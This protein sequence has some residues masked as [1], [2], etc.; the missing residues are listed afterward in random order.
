MS[1]H[2]PRRWR[3]GRSREDGEKGAEPARRTWGQR[4]VLAG[5]VL[6]SLAFAVS[7][8]GLGYAYIKAGSI[9]R[10]ELSNELAEEVEAG[11]PRNVLMVGVDS[12]EG[13]DEDDPILNERDHNVPLAD[14]IM[15]LRIDPQQR[16]AALLSIPRD[17]WVTFPATQAEG[18]INSALWRGDGH[19]R[20][21]IDLLDSLFGI[22][23]H[24]YVEVDFAGFKELVDE[25]DGVPVW[26]DY[27]ARDDYSGLH[28]GGSGCV[29][30]DGDQ[31]LAYA[32]SRHHYDYIDG[33]WEPESRSD[34]ARIERQQDL[35]QRTADRAISRGARN[36]G[37]L[38]RLLDSALR[39]VTVDDELTPADILDL[40]ERFRSFDPHTLQTYALPTED[41][42][43]GAAQVQQLV[44]HEAEPILDLFR[45]PAEPP[46]GGPQT[47]DPLSP[48]GPQDGAVT[49]G[50]RLQPGEVSLAVQNGSGQS[51]Q[52]TEAADQLSGA[53]FSVISRTNASQ[54]G[55]P[56]TEVR[57]PE[58][59]EAEAATV[60]S[61]LVSGAELVES[62][63]VAGVTVVTG[64]DWDGVLD[65]PRPADSLP[66]SSP[67]APGDGTGSSVDITSTT[68]GTRPGPDTS[69]TVATTTTT[70]PPKDVHRC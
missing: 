57:Y 54:F 10:V 69:T 51:G 58:G 3:L 36:P 37:T 52:A 70:Q 31:A 23:I 68:D 1:L 28:I 49:S 2:L 64:A 38:N 65:E 24:H 11:S 59:L 39:S 47:D 45:S 22:P 15:I 16:H 63:D 7:S 17:L 42:R 55:L 4:L 60:A 33:Q 40:A 46:S 67:E 56:S 26:F 66:S 12:T 27:P 20:V 48:P 14:S 19:P 29:T 6:G 9:P 50:E 18:R 5:G 32:R 41:D 8:A 34:L 13:L 61:W 62:S 30:L 53:G 44:E 25:L 43:V 21:L 35:L